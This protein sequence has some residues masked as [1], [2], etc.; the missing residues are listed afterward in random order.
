[1]KSP[2]RLRQDPKW[3]YDTG[4][5]YAVWMCLL[6]FMAVP[7]W[8]DDT[9]QSWH[10]NVK[11]Q[12]GCVHNFSF[13]VT[14]S[15]ADMQGIG[16]WGCAENQKKLLEE[17]VFLHQFRIFF[18]CHPQVQ[19]QCLLIRPTAYEHNLTH[20]RTRQTKKGSPRFPRG[21]GVNELPLG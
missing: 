10:K 6:S 19:L 8:R 20:R 1:M 18:L 17:G 12:R 3:D 14:K 9:Q 15:P 13:E 21:M 11:S 7:T 5:Q 16:F 4:N 2:Y